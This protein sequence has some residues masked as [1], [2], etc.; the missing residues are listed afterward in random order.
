MY[1]GMEEIG[2]MAD[3]SESFYAAIVFVQKG[4]I[5]DA[6][7]ILECVQSAVRVI[8]ETI[9]AQ[10]AEIKNVV[11]VLSEIIGKETRLRG[12]IMQELNET[13][14]DKYRRISDNTEPLQEKVEEA[15]K[16]IGEALEFESSLD[17]FRDVW[18]DLEATF[19]GLANSNGAFIDMLQLLDQ[20]YDEIDRK[21]P[22]ASLLIHRTTIAWDVPKRVCTTV[23]NSTR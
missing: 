4:R 18:A 22:S 16:F 8:L 21:C 17:S 6:I 3:A 10:E 13:A 11:C 5:Q 14:P 9:R 20:E 19:S 12:D 15:H 7:G 2:T 1:L 23:Y